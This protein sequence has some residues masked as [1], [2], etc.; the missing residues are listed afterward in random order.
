MG[1]QYLN[2]GAEAVQMV[3]PAAKQTMVTNLLN[4]PDWLVN[5]AKRH[6]NSRIETTF[7]LKGK[8]TLDGSEEVYLARFKKSLAKAI[9][10]GLEVP[11][12][13][14]LNKETAELGANKILEVAVETGAYNWEFD[15]S[16][17]FEEFRRNPK[18]T[19]GAYPTLPLTLPYSGFRDFCLTL[20]GE[21]PSTM[22]FVS[23][24]YSALKT[25]GEVNSSFNVLR[26]RDF[27]T[28]NPDSTVTTNPLFSDIVETYIGNLANESFDEIL[29]NSNRELR[30]H[31][32]RHRMRPCYTCEYFLSCRGGPSHVP[33]YDGSGE[34]AGMK[35]LWAWGEVMRHA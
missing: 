24:F 12:N 28:I 17:D 5:L 9:S 26:E 13:V 29:S 21:I 35:K 23:S 31:E 20:G 33:L 10:N 25:P 18:F 27:I 4:M 2:A 16:V 14:E 11:V 32:E 34:C 8:A 19:S 7:A 15:I 30:I 3:V 6:Y 22:P 1:E